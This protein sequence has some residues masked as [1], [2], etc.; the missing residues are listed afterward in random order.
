MQAAS[1]AAP[2]NRTRVEI[3]AKMLTVADHGALKTHIMYKANLS[4]KQLES[5]L[6]F[7]KAKGLLEEVVNEDGRIYQLT[8]KGNEFLKDYVKLSAHL[9]GLA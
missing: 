9:I 4:H 2:R 8:Q 3:L 7:L 5:Y 6:E 1:E